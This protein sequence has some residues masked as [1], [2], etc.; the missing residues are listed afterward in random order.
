ML[1][2]DRVGESPLGNL[3]RL[4]TMSAKVTYRVAKAIKAVMEEVEAFEKARVELCK[5]L[6]TLNPKTN[7]YDMDEEKQK[8][9]Q[10]SMAELLQQDV[11]LNILEV[12]I[13]PDAV[14]LTPSDML[15]LEPVI[16]V[17]ET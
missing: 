13:D 17:R 5:E 3:G 2:V 4:K 6:G 16:K 1:M 7:N 10:T 9:F 14:G 11:V 15:I 12:E 8:E